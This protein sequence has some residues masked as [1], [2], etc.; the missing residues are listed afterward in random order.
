MAPK[1]PDLL[2][3]ATDTK[4]GRLTMT[5]IVEMLTNRQIQQNHIGDAE[6]DFFV[7]ALHAGPKL[8]S[9]VLD[10]LSSICTCD[11]QAMPHH[12]HLITNK[13]FKSGALVQFQL[14][15][16]AKARKNE[17]GKG[18][19]GDDQEQPQP[20]QQE[21]GFKWS[22]AIAAV[23]SDDL[24]ATMNPLTVTF[25]G[26]PPNYWARIE[27]VAVVLN[28]D[29][30]AFLSAQVNLMAKLCEGRNYVSIREVERSL[31]V[32]PMMQCLLDQRLPAPLR[33][34]FVS[35]LMAVFIDRKPQRR[36]RL[37]NMTVLW[38]DVDHAFDEPGSAEARGSLSHFRGLKTSIQRYLSSMSSSGA[39]AGVGGGDASS[40]S[41]SNHQW[42]SLT[43]H[44][45][46]LFQM[47][48]QFQ[49]HAGTCRYIDLLDAKRTSR[50]Q[51]QTVARSTALPI[52]ARTCT[53]AH[54]R[55]VFCLFALPPSSS[56]L[57][58]RGIFRHCTPSW[59][60]SGQ[61]VMAFKRM[62]C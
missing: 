48:Y 57:T 60:C 20:Q 25:P 15:A 43:Q 55:A 31:T 27:S 44:L 46:E 10:V 53:R 49:V 3:L 42:T 50:W 13:I 22:R 4:I 11:G 2:S 26:D 16:K 39:G 38:S 18:A 40:A 19:S 41:T 1:F 62:T 21:S 12:Q 30:V 35:L 47:L 52:R 45:L 33:S 59:V 6:V 17:K 54:S 7:A 51:W 29:K 24:A 58:R 14:L 37:K 8:N 34:S 56:R 36:V 9:A 28:R 32:E 61:S 23:H 5:C